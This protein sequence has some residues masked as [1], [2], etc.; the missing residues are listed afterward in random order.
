MLPEL[1][2][3][4][5]INIHED[6]INKHPDVDWVNETAQQLIRDFAMLQINLEFEPLK[7]DKYQE[8]FKQATAIIGD[9]YNH[10]YHVFLNLLYRIDLDEGRL[11][12]LLSAMAP[13][14][15]YEQIT[16]Q[17]LKREFMKVVS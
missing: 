16:E 1:W 3:N 15:L 5:L 10:N 11:H 2:K 17:I 12:Q 13:P 6:V 4:E 8:L 14:R 7:N 9:L